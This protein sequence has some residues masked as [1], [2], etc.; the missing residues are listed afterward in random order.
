LTRTR[1][2]GTVHI[3]AGTYLAGFSIIKD[4]ILEGEGAERTVLSGS[5]WH[6]LYIVGKAV[7]EIR[8]LQVSGNGD[9]GLIVGDSANVSLQD[10]T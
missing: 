4:L 1:P 10:S 6:G 8:N 7:V 2:G 5:G 9:G 3:R